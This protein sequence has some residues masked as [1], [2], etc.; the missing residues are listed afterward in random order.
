MLSAIVLAAGSSARMGDRNKL[1]LPYRK[2]PL[3]A[4]T[5]AHILAAGI[6]ELI[7][8]TGHEAQLIEQAAGHLS[9]QVVHNPAYRDGMTGS[10]QAG[11]SAA[12]GN[13]YMICLADMVR[14]TALEYSLLKVAFEERV[15]LDPECICVP[16]YEGQEG[17]PVIFSAFY[18]EE[19][20]Q[21]KEKSGCKGIVRTHA[22]H[23]YRVEMPQDHILFDID[24]PNEYDALLKEE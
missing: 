11:V 13:G 19:I 1:L 9:L 20:L 15:R 24:Y 18:R 22:E 8:V 14:V 5:L 4:G 2:M 21:H 12:G 3:L 17:N 7:L 10:I 6:E 16:I 23:I